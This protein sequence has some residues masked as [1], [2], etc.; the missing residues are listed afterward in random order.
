[1][2][3]SLLV[4]SQRLRHLWVLYKVLKG[5]CPRKTN[6]LL[7]DIRYQGEG[8]KTATTGFLKW[9]LANLNDARVDDPFSTTN[10]LGRGIRHEYNRGSPGFYPA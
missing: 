9:E 10:W 3:H 4:F 5:W 8:H 1:M 2:E 6:V 7:V